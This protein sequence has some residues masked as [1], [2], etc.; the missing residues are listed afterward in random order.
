MSP[1]LKSIWFGDGTN[2]TT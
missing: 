2:E 1:F